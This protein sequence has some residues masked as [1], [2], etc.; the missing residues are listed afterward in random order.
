MTLPLQ[1]TPLAADIDTIFDRFWSD[2]NLP[3]PLEQSSSPSLDVYEKDGTYVADM[4]VPG[5]KP[6]NIDVEVSG[7]VLT[8]T[9]KYDY[10]TKADDVKYHRREI[11]RGSFERTIALPQEMEP[12]SVQAKTERGILHI[13]ARPLKAAPNT[14]VKVTGG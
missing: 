12:G 14:K 6:E 3:T 10:D 8:I 2:W 9:G 1:R 11:R 4:A 5:Y 7:N 13:T